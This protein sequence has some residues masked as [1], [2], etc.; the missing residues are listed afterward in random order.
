M[1]HLLLKTLTEQVRNLNKT[2]TQ[3]WIDDVL[4][5]QDRNILEKESY[6]DSKF[7]TLQLRKKLFDSFKQ[8]QAQ[9]VVKKTNNARI[10][11]L[12]E[13]KNHTYPWELWGRIF[14]WFGKPTS[15]SHWQIYLYASDTARTL[16]SSGP[17]G[18]DNLNGG[19]TYPCKSD[20][21]VIYRYEEATRV[22]IHELLHAS[23]T[24]NHTNP[25]EVKEA[26]TEVWAE[27]LLVAL[28]GD[29]DILKT[30]NLW[31][32][33]D[34]HIQDLNYTVSTFYNNDYGARYTTMRIPVLNSLGMLLDIKYKPKRITSSRFTSEKLLF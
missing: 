6:S 17:I 13:N 34:H 8:N 22:L 28:L 30:E 7:D 26:A 11:I 29:G 4:I 10:V 33:Q 5:E 27:L 3:V 14:Q 20:C 16:P 25:V 31:K 12:E 32:V 18:P 15:G 1:I 23:C 2:P 19:Y 9:T 24:D 21:I